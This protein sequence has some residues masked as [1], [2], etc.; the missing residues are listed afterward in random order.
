MLDN[1]GWGSLILDIF[2]EGPEKDSFLYSTCKILHIELSLTFEGEPKK[3][4]LVLIDAEEPPL[5]FL[6]NTV[7]RGIFNNKDIPLYRSDYPAIFTNEVSYL[8]YLSVADDFNFINNLPPTKEELMAILR[9]DPTCLKGVLRIEDAQAVLDGIE[10]HPR[11]LNLNEEQERRI[12]KAFT[13]Y[14]KSQ[15]L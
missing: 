13:E 9:K 5:F 15:E 12:M 10:D 7:K 3:K 2:P 14:I 11:D 4:F 6:I 1:S 8:H